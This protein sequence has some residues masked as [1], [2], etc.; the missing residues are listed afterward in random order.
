MPEAVKQDFTWRALTLAVTVEIVSCIGIYGDSFSRTTANVLVDFHIVL[1][2]PIYCL[3]YLLG[4]GPVFQ[5]ANGCLR[6]TTPLSIAAITV[7][8]CIWTWLF[9]VLMRFERHLRG[10][11]TK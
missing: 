4:I 1:N 11:R 5:V 6:L 7:Q 9:L 2:L 10:R 8:C 3:L